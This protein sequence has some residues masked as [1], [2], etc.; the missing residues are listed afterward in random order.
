M[1]NLAVVK[2]HHVLQFTGVTDQTFVPYDNVFAKV[3]IVPDLTAPSN[4]RGSFN[5]G[6][7]LNHGSLAD[8]NIRTDI[9]AALAAVVEPRTSMLLEILPDALQHLPR[10][11]AAFEQ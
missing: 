10:P 3:S 2:Q 7:I 6:A 8:P 4:D 1:G 5:H 11:L 9:G